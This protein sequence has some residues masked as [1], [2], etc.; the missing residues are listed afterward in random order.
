MTNALVLKTEQDVKVLFTDGYFGEENSVM[1]LNFD[2]SKHLS[3]MFQ[4]LRLIAN[5]L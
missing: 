5:Q 4:A 2:T 3:H 1:Y